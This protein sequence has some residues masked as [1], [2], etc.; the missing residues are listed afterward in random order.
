MTRDP[1]RLPDY[2]GHILEAIQRIERYVGSIGEADFLASEIVQDAVIRNLEVIG[3]ASRNIERAH[4]DFAATHPELPLTL[5][6]DMR[7][8]L[9]LLQGRP[10]DR[11][12]DHP[13]RLTPV[14]VRRARDRDGWEG[15]ALTTNGHVRR[16]EVL[17]G[18]DG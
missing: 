7:N 14:A 1:Q 9:S 6:S 12:E 5:A 2:L 3:E 16:S 4:P 17:G 11:L 10:A 18:H 13:A 8:A 15:R